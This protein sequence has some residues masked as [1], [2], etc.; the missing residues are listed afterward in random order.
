[1]S[2]VRLG[3]KPW[4]LRI[5]HSPLSCSKVLYV[6]TYIAGSCVVA[7]G[8][9]LAVKNLTDKLAAASRSG[10]TRL[11]KI[12]SRSGLYYK[13]VWRLTRLSF[14]HTSTYHLEVYV[15]YIIFKCIYSDIL[16]DILLGIYSDKSDIHSGILSG[17]YSAILSGKYIL[18]FYLA[19]I[20][21]LY[22]AFSLAWVRVQAHSTT[23]WSCIC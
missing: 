3:H 15:A 19:S 1:M 11:E 20:L 4:C 21:T 2:H 12:L 13:L 7:L 17:I 22:L 23:S 5:N 14:W 16:S 10:K 6:Q 8:Q 18:T 9:D